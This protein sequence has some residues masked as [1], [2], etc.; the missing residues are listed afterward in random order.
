MGKKMAAFPH[1]PARVRDGLTVSSALMTLLPRLNRGW[2][3]QQVPFSLSGRAAPK[4]S[5]LEG[6]TWEAG[7]HCRVKS[8]SFS[9]IVMGGSGPR[10]GGEWEAA[11]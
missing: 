5:L 11:E 3:L 2:C 4:L 6:S 10:R 7:W 9:Y 8:R 1:S